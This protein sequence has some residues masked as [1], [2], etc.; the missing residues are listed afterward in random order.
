VAACDGIISSAVVIVL[1]DCTVVER[2]K[3]KGLRY[4]AKWH[5]AEHVVYRIGTVDINSRNI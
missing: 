5:V 4:R 1:F 3:L 2:S